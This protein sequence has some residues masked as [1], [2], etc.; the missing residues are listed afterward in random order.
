MLR[1]EQDGRQAGIDVPR[2]CK[3]NLH[4]CRTRAKQRSFF[5]LPT[6]IHGCWMRHGTGSPKTRSGEPGEHN[7]GINIIAWSAKNPDASFGVI[8]TI[9]KLTEG[10]EKLFDLAGAGP[11]AGVRFLSSS[12]TDEY[13][14]FVFEVARIDACLRRA[15]GH[16]WQ[17]GMTDE[18]FKRVK[19]FARQV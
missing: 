11:L 2:A 14:E 6:I 13:A 7:A 17:C 16:V 5:S 15:F 4:S 18:R 10:D 19:E 8:Q 3:T 12:R 1:G 9:L